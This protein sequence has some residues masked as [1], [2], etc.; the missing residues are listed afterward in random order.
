MAQREGTQL[1][2][3]TDAVVFHPRPRPAAH[4]RLAGVPPALRGA[5]SLT[6]SGL[7]RS[8]SATRRELGRRAAGKVRSDRHA[9]GACRTSTRE[10]SWVASRFRDP[11]RSSRAL[12]AM[13]RRNAASFAG[14]RG[15]RA[16]RGKKDASYLGAG[17]M[18]PDRTFR[19]FHSPPPERESVADEQHM[20]GLRRCGF[21]RRVRRRI[22]CACAADQEQGEEQ[23]Q[24]FHRCQYAPVA[25]ASRSPRIP[26]PEPLARHTAAGPEHPRCPR[27]REMLTSWIPQRTLRV[28]GFCSAETSGHSESSSTTGQPAWARVPEGPGARLSVCST[29]R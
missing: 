21:G 17:S 4:R 19:C 25:L 14:G 15:W 10:S 12:Q 28:L 24:V 5:V 9:C 27:P 1:T 18:A 29:A 11:A 16:A 6:I 20:R 13:S 7:R 2:R 23:E 26:G 8:C 22:P 3:L